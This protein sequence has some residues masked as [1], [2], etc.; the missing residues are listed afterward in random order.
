MRRL[1]PFV[2]LIACVSVATFAYPSMAQDTDGQA[3]KP[4]MM[5]KDADPDWDVVTVKPS[6]SEGKNAGFH[7]QGQR[8][9]IQHRTVK[10][11]LIIGYGMHEKQLV[12]M[13]GW[14]ES[15]RWDVEGVVDVEG[16]PS[17]AQL[18]SL[19]R[20]TLVERFGLRTHM[21]TRELGVYALTVAKGGP[22][23][24]QSKGDPKESMSENDNDR[25]GQRTM[26]V[27]NASMGDFALVMRYSADRPAVDHTGLTGRYDFQLKWALDDSKESV[28]GT[29]GPGLFTALQE[30][31]GLK[32]EP[33]KAPVDVLVVDKV[34]RP[35]AN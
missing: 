21:E 31:L 19:V 30:Q 23:L 2:T 11:M 27:M 25:A 16:K 10:D 24:E 32:L 18:Q 6:D 33:T 1:A 26:R 20:K 29:L 15:D 12:G 9:T 34:E 3:A 4:A 13:P 7:S 5:A 35:G 17:L 28:D 14:A 8:M 22:K